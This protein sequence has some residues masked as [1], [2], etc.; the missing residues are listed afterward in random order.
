MFRRVSYIA[1][2]AASAPLLFAASVSRAQDSG[3]EPVDLGT[4]TL[5]AST[6]PCALS[7]T[8]VS[9]D[10]VG[11]GKLR[12]APLSLSNLLADLPGV[13]LSANGGPGTRTVCA[14]RAAGLLYRHED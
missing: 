14:A 8:G 13:T 2:I 7:R 6:S 3:E 12:D 11:A 5:T 9:V 1:M 10:V 4:I